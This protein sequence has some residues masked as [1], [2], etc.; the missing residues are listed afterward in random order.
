M[1]LEEPADEHSWHHNNKMENMDLAKI[2][3]YNL[4]Y[5]WTCFSVRIQIY[6]R[7][8]IVERSDI[9]RYRTGPIRFL[10]PP[11]RFGGQF[12]QLIWMKFK[13]N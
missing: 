1:K 13:E 12:F 7:W 10:L 9:L 8:L 5:G 6:V 4:L 3:Q 2:V 11:V